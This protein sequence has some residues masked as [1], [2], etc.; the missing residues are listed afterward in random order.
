[1]MTR[2]AWS[3]TRWKTWSRPAK[4]H[5]TADCRLRK[6]M[7]NITQN[8][9]PVYVRQGRSPKS[10]KA[11]FI[12]A[13]GKTVIEPTFE[14]ARPFSEGL[15]SVQLNEKWGAIDAT[16]KLAIPFVHTVGLDFSSGV[17]QF[18][19]GA[20]RVLLTSDGIVILQPKYCSISRF[21]ADGIAY[22]SDGSHYG[23]INLRGE[24]VIPLFFEDAR[25]FSEGVAP[26]LVDGRWGYI[27]Q[28]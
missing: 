2:E 12:D 16:G 8:L 9:Y 5:L 20:L 11:G 22:V 15:A 27:N 28:R 4:A 6:L 14:D 18:E 13:T 1:M 21:R 19:K 26:V 3:L 25:E 23:F 17:A 7:M 10:Y 24:Q